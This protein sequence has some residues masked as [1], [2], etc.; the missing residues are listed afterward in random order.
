MRWVGRAGQGWA[1][2]WVLQ[3]HGAGVASISLSIGLCAAIQFNAK[4]LYCQEKEIRIRLHYQNAIE[5]VENG[6]YTAGR[7]TAFCKPVIQSQ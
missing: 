5:T 7:G 6:M 2:G 1:M 3:I 4:E